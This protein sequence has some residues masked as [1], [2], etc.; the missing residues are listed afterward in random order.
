MPIRE[1]P[2]RVGKPK[3]IAGRPRRAA[4]HASGG[5]LAAGRRKPTGWSLIELLVA[6]SIMLV[7]GGVLMAM[8]SS[9]WQVWEVLARS[10]GWTAS[11]PPWIE[12]LEADLAS[13]VVTAGIGLSGDARQLTLVRPSA[14]GAPGLSHVQY[15]W[16]DD[17]LVRREQPW[18]WPGRDPWALMPAAATLRLKAG[19]FALAYGEIDA[20]GNLVWHAR[21]HHPKQ[22]PAAV[23][24][25][26][27]P[28]GG[29]G[30]VE[31]IMRLHPAP[32]LPDEPNEPDGEDAR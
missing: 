20:D 2:I 32:H 30:A 24:V 11:A 17:G 7:T 13:H 23:R 9:G 18:R 16:D 1:H 19:A 10:A 5:C 29:S 15:A 27:A 3:A 26:L 22:T 8:L 12:R 21:W 6:L 31:R 14:Q 4:G 28:P 25:R